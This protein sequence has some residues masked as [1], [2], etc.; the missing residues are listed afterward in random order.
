M[1]EQAAARVND[2]VVDLAA[3]W[4][5]RLATL[6]D[7]PEFRIWRRK[8][9]E[10][11]LRFSGFLATAQGPRQI[12]AL[13]DTGATHCFICARLAATLQLSPSPAGQPGLMSVMTA[14]KGEALGLA[15]PVL[16]YLGVGVTFREVADGL[17]YGRG[18]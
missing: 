9:P 18:R 1:A 11:K 3:A 15:A 5:A 14:S 12:T 16:I 13:I 6:T 10:F 2:S 4:N 17:E 8:N 7:L